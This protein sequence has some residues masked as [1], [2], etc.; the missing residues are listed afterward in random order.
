LG[1]TPHRNCAKNGQV[2]GLAFIRGSI[3]VAMAATV[4]GVV[5]AQPSDVMPPGAIAAPAMPAVV[6]VDTGFQRYL[7]ELRARALAEGVRAQ[8]VDAILPTLT[9]NSRVVELDRN[10]PD[11]SRPSTIPRLSDYLDRRLTTAQIEAGR[12][13][14]RSLAARLPAIE[15]KTGVPGNILVAIWGM[16]TNYGGYVGDFDI[17]RSLAS[18]A[19]DG[20]RRE[21][22]SRE[23]IAALKILDRGY[24]NREMLVGSWAGAMGHPQ[25]LPTSYLARAVDGDG[26]GRIDIW[27]SSL[28][29]LASIGNYL[30]D[31]G[32]QRGQRWGMEV[33]VPAAMDRQ[34]VRNLTVSETCPR[35]HARHSRWLTVGEWRQL[36]IRPLNAA[37][38]G[39]QTM[40]TLIEPDGPGAR[41]FLTFGNYR[42]L[43]DYNCSNF[44]ALSVALLADHVAR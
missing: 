30:A 9:F 23:F 44:Y 39:D 35:V 5:R 43:L 37:W 12:T 33:F 34:A 13:R 16:E 22:F 31:A 14:Y 36:G 28:D 42:A 1:F 32:W 10:Q 41:A 29:A 15:A 40:A 17:L 38:P 2:R 11:D 26:D 24:V 19:Y 18:L 20:R 21:L 4:P 6:E 25:F 3:C 27:R 8:T 7:A